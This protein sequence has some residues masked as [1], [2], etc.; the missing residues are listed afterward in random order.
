[1]DDI[2]K[3]EGDC[4]KLPAFALLSCFQ[5][6]GYHMRSMK[7]TTPKPIAFVRELCKHKTEEEILEAEENYRRYLRLVKKICERL[8][9]EESQTAEIDKQF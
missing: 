5:I 1:M 8:E 3:K 7:Q 9:S 6:R 4:I 2:F